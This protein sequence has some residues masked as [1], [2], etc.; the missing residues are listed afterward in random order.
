MKKGQTLWLSTIIAIISL[1][2]LGF[3]FFS[4]TYL[5]TIEREENLDIIFAGRD[6]Q[7]V[8]DTFL[9]SSA[10]LSQEVNGL[11]REG[12][13][14]ADLLRKYVSEDDSNTQAYLFKLK[15]ERYFGID[16]YGK[17]WAITV[18]YYD[19]NLGKWLPARHVNYFTNKPGDDRF[20]ISKGTIYQET[21]LQGGRIIITERRVD[22]DRTSDE[23][24]LFS[25]GVTVVPGDNGPQYLINRVYQIVPNYADTGKPLILITLYTDEL[26]SI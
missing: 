26:V 25:R 17:Y 5:T 10:S 18:H 13:T 22:I 2:I 15:T 4:M 1:I 24:F 6:S 9:R 14:M 7:V 21:G 16:N 3:I 11:P 23:E 8:L 12:S 19:A 20:Y